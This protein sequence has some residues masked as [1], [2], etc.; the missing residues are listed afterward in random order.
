MSDSKVWYT[1]KTIWFNVLTTALAIIGFL[2]VTQS[3][4]GL[5]FDIDAKWLLIAAGIINIILRAVTNQPLSG[6][7]PQ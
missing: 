4:T 1:S 7:K 5:P 3:T 2:M 6:S